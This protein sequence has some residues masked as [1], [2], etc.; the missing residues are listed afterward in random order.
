MTFEEFTKNI[1]NEVEESWRFPAYAFPQ[2]VITP[3][4]ILRYIERDMLRFKFV[5]ERIKTIGHAKRILDIGCAYGFYDIYLKEN[6]GFDVTGMEVKTNVDAYCRLLFSHGIPVIQGGLSKDACPV[7]DHSYDIVILSEVFE[8]LR[9]SPIR[10]LNEIK[11]ILTPDGFFLLTTP[12]MGCL[13]NVI[14]LLMGKNILQPFP[15][16]DTNLI[17]ITDGINHIRIYVLN[18][19]VLLMK[20]VGFKIVEA[21]YISADKMNLKW[22]RNLPIHVAYLALVKVF[23]SLRGYLYVV[24]KNESN[25]RL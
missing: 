13:R 10:I 12:N 16:D 6:Y 3:Q 7:P 8:H 24:G 4:S 18:E 20:K 9:V 17:H 1:R 15:E 23:P 11:R 21:G 22:R 14:H 5:A 25:G 19:I 2:E